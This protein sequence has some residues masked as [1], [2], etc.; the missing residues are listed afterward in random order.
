MWFAYVAIVVLAWSSAVLFY[1]KQGHQN[2]GY[3]VSGAFAALL[4]VLL[5]SLYRWYQG[6]FW[7]SV[8][9]AETLRGIV[10]P[11]T[12]AFST[13]G[14]QESGPVTTVRVAWRDIQRIERVGARTFIVIAPLIAIVI[15]ASAFGDDASRVQFEQ[16]LA[17]H[18]GAEAVAAH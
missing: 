5:P 9:S 6:S 4:T 11:T 3:L 1:V 7:R 16:Q 8:L 14:V 13:E 18:V 10:G 2:R 12:L 15:P 17:V